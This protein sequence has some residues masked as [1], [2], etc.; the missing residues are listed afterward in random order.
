VDRSSIRSTVLFPKRPTR[1][2]EQM[3]AR[4]PDHGNPLQKFP[5]SSEEPKNPSDV[6]SALP[7]PLYPA[8]SCTRHHPTR[9]YSLLEGIGLMF[10][11]E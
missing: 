5:N 2:A 4:Y 8:T 11:L 7:L 10:L 6:P 9:L 3:Q 1:M